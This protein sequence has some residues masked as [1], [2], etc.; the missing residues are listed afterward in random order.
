MSVPQQPKPAK[1]VVGLIMKRKSLLPEVAGDLIRQFGPPDLV[2]RWLAFDFTAYYEPELGSPLF[3]RMLAFQ[4]PIEQKN[5][6]EIKLTTNA[7]EK[8]HSSGGKRQVNI[9]PGYLTHERFVLATGKNYAH[10]IYLDKG[11][12]ADLTLMFRKGGY[13]ALPWTYPDYAHHQIISFLE[14]VRSKYAFDIRRKG[15]TPDE[16]MQKEPS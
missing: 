11:I 16:S 13:E 3:R 12:Y 10:R 1:L 4:A 6:A 7:I 8:T 2:S 15:V 9:D 5:L 14:R